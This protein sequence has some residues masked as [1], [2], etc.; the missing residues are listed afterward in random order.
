MPEQ[1]S[2][3]VQITDG[4]VFLDQVASAIGRYGLRLPALLALQM[5]HPVTFLGG[6]LL[7]MAQPALALFMPTGWVQHLAM[8]LEEPVA[9]QGLRMRLENNEAQ[10]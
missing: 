7:W 3:H 10:V 4:E 8:V 6:Q 2:V 5:G 9:V 1:N